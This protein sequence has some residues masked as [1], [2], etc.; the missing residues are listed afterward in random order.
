MQK[1]I[2]C[3]LCHKQTVAEYCREMSEPDDDITEGQEADYMMAEMSGDYGEWGI[4]VYRGR[5][6]NCKELFCLKVL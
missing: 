5:C 4:D 6:V 3:P 1:E 2:E